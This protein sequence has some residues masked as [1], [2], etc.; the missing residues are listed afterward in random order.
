MSIIFY[1]GFFFPSKF[2]FFSSS[3][4]LDSL[5][6]DYCNSFYAAILKGLIK[7]VLWLRERCAHPARTVIPVIQITLHIDYRCVLHTTQH[8]ILNVLI[9]LQMS[10]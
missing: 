10:F 1:V 8:Q 4:H 3:S 2:G 7:E 5:G 6:L 9:G